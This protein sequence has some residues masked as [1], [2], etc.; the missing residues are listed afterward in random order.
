M[1]HWINTNYKTL[2]ITAFLI[3]IITVAIVSISH[4]TQWYG[5]S[6]PI[7]WAVYLSVGIEIAA[8][9]ALAAI[10]A[11]MGKN[12]YFPFIIVTLIQF[13]GN[14]FFAYEYID[15]TNEM[16]KS[17]VE[18]VSPLVSF[19]GVDPT[20]FIGHKR[21]LSLF[22]GGL[23]PV[24]SLSFLHMLV[25][26]T[27]EDRLKDVKEEE[28]IRQKEVDEIIKHDVEDKTKHDVEEIVTVDSNLLKNLVDDAV[29]VKLSEKDLEILEKVLLDPP[30]PSKNLKKTAEKHKQSIDEISNELDEEILEIVPEKESFIS[31]VPEGNTVDYVPSTELT[32][33]EIEEKERLKLREEEL[34]KLENFI[35]KNFE[36]DPNKEDPD[37]IYNE[38]YDEDLEQ[39][40]NEWDT[41]LMD[42][43]ED[44]PYSDDLSIEEPIAEEFDGDSIDEYYPIDESIL[45]HEE[46]K[47]KLTSNIEESELVAD[48]DKKKDQL[49]I[50]SQE[51]NSQFLPLEELQDL[52]NDD[53]NV[54]FKEGM[55]PLNI[56]RKIVSRNVNNTKRRG[57]R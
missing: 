47:K 40:I 38:I 9:S 27:E 16:F 5:I 51:E 21:F 22:A 33:E 57:F 23:L 17:W 2:I 6:N 26:F 54:Y 25:K 15:V 29:K 3:P 36:P 32:K 30:K 11:N 43:L 45:A 24:I 12:V 37:E 56:N 10:S 8:M 28:Y 48:P 53:N 19:I 14:I 7:S 46:D 20:D 52:T 35:N 42:G 31:D 41:T 44:E 49:E 34:S 18:L 13:L 4:V 1:R 55:D 50:Q 39:D